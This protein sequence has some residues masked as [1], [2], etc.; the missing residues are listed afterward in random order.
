M[1][2]EYLVSLIRNK[3]R[4]YERKQVNRVSVAKKIQA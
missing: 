3:I 4:K 2:R 1:G